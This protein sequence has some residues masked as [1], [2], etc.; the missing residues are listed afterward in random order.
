MIAVQRCIIF[1]QKDALQHKMA[2][3]YAP[4]IKADQKLKHIHVTESD[5]GM[6]GEG[7]VDCEAMFKAVAEINYKGPLV[8]ENFSSKINE[9]VGSTWLW[10]PSKYNSENQAKGSLLFMKNIVNNWC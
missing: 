7:N 5:R 9:L 10:R 3:F 8:L 6:T 1:T 4:I 2:N